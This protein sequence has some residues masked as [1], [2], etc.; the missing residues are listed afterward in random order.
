MELATAR[1]SRTQAQINR[2]NG[3]ILLAVIALAI[4]GWIYWGSHHDSVEH[5][6]QNL[7][8]AEGH[9]HDLSGYKN[10]WSSAMDHC[11]QSSSELE[12][13]IENVLPALR[14]QN[15]ANQDRYTLLM[16]I[17]LSVDL[18]PKVDCAPL[19]SGA[20]ILPGL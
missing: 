3:L 19:L 20:H 14:E 13:L 4:G 12:N 9:A 11:T 8:A 18:G 1:P 16:N 5:R 15:P 10:L 7:D 6:L 2:R 17:S